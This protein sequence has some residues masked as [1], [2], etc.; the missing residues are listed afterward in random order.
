MPKS[1]C[2]R[3][4]ICYA[5]KFLQKSSEGLYT[6]YRLH[7]LGSVDIANDS[8]DIALAK[9]QMIRKASKSFFL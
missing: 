6:T 9:V 4:L 1:L 3:V 8:V 5:S 7:G 2:N